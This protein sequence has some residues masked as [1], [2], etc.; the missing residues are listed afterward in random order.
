MV[1]K[2]TPD[3]VVA[4]ATPLSWKDT[5]VRAVKTA[6]G[7]LIGGL[8]VNSLASLDI[9]TAKV[10]IIAAASAGGSVVLNAILRWSNS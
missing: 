5:L 10:A 6:V 8:P 2:K 3:T 7:V 4:L 1:T 9:S